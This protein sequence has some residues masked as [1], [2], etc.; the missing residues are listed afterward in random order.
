MK[1][2][3]IKFEKRQNK[4]YFLFKLNNNIFVKIVLHPKR[5]PVL[6]L[7]TY[8]YPNQNSNKVILHF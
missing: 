8:I 6:G 4:Q 3:K 5:H 1:Y 2:T 7:P